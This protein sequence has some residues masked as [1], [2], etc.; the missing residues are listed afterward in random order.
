MLGIT[1]MIAL[2]Y[3]ALIA[4]CLYA[5]RRGC[6]RLARALIFA[7]GIIALGLVWLWMRSPM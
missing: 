4:L 2:G 7:M 3:L 5:L 1:A 6:K